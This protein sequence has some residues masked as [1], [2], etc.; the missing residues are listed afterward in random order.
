MPTLARWFIKT[1]L[2]YLAAALVLG[3]ALALA[4]VTGWNLPAAATMAHLHL[5]VV[6]WLTQLIFGVAYWLFPRHSREQP[7]GMTPLAWLA[8]ATL[9]GGLLLRTVAE[10][11]QAVSAWAGWGIALV[12]AGVF[13]AAA[14]VAFVVYIWP[15][16]QSKEQRR[17]PA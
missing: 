5:L 16:V 9:N 3:A 1:A 14:G 4:P 13:Q 8:Y 6:G 10:P 7:F 17:K 15:R 12:A 2:A 11:A